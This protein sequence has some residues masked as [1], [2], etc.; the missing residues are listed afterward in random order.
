[1]AIFCT[2]LYHQKF[3]S[4]FYGCN[5]TAIPI[6][7]LVHSPNYTQPSGLGIFSKLEDIQ[8]STN[9]PFSKSF[10]LY[11]QTIISTDYENKKL[12]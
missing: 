4:D 1:M 2:W 9:A 12:K 10:K 8:V 3:G 11:P 6:K 7:Q 5:L